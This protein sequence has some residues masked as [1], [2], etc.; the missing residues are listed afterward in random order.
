MSNPASA[1]PSEFSGRTAVICGIGGQ[2]GAYLAAHLL[3]LGY[4]VVG[5]SRDAQGGRFTGLEALGIRDRVGHAVKHL[6]ILKDDIGASR[7]RAS[8][9]IGPA[10]ARG[11]KAHLG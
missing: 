5:T 4:S 10:I 8:R 7:G 1:P 9:G 11:N 3:A 2:D 6:G